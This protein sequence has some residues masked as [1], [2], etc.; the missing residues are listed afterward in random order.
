MYTSAG[1]FLVYMY[2]FPKFQKKKNPNLKKKVIYI[3]I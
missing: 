2:F 1:I 3:Y